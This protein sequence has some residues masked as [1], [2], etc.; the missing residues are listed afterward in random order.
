MEKKE[1]RKERRNKGRKKRRLQEIK[2]ECTV[3]MHFWFMVT[4]VPAYAFHFNNFF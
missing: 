2:K 3:K 1:R 4:P